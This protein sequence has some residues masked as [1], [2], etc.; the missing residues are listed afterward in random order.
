MS[1]YG[2]NFEFLQSPLPQHRL[3]RYVT[4]A[5]G[6]VIPLG[7]PVRVPTGAVA[8]AEG[9]LP[10]ELCTGAT[11]P[12][13]G[14][15]GILIHEYAFLAERGRDPVQTVVSDYDTAPLNAPSQL[16]YGDE[17]KVRLINTV[18]RSFQGQRAYTGR[19]V[20]GGLGATPTVAVG[21]W[22]TPGVGDDTSGYWAVT[23]TKAQAWF[24]VTLVDSTFVEAQMLF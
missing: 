22:L 21:N 20:I 15:H 12:E 6:A 18:A 24:Y 16:C 23:A 14:R 11:E 9:R 8:N 10:L 13:V 2:R 17:C 4:K 5:T 3:G 7:A 19:V 1:N